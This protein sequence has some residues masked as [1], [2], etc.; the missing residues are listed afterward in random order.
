M[1]LSGSMVVVIA[2]PTASGKS[3]LALTLAE[4]CRG[5]IINADASQLY[6]DLRILSARPSAAEEARVPH[7]LYGVIDGA[8]AAN[9]A[10]WAAMAKNA[11]A[12]VQAAGRLPILVGGTGMYLATLIDGIAP[13]PDIDSQVRAAVR[14]MTTE[15]AAR[16]LVAEDPAAA[17]RLGPTDRQ[18]IL[19]ALEVAR[20][21]G[22]TLKQWQ[23][24]KQGGIGALCDVRA[25]VVDVPRDTLYA[26]AETRLRAMAAA[27]AAEEAA[28]LMARGLPADRP[29]LRALGVAEFAAVAAGAM[30]EE[31]AILAVAQ[32]TRHYQKRQ[33][34]W[35]R[36]QRPD[37][38]RLAAGDLAAVRALLA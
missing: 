22:R 27:G 38:P 8:E 3:A 18:R 11:I 13:V 15:D 5:S 6:A 1:M 10:R 29:V 23:H 25:M 21:T 32:E 16:A 2:G 20:A 33:S 4:K 37:W 31:A 17:A 35:L 26:R 7:L 19:R 34:T 14:A 28:R 12:E 30:D 36:N 9:A 24:S